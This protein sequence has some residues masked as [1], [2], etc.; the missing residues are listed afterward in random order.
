[1]DLWNNTKKEEKN[2]TFQHTKSQVR[3][4]LIHFTD[5]KVSLRKSFVCNQIGIYVNPNCEIRWNCVHFNCVPFR[6]WVPPTLRIVK[7]QKPLIFHSNGY[8]HFL[9]CDRNLTE[10]VAIRSLRIVARQLV[11]RVEKSKSGDAAKSE[12]HLITDRILEHRAIKRR[13]INITEKYA[14]QPKQ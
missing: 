3:Q 14:Q 12:L 1:M 11:C 5:T 2:L 7:T 13:A 6:Q 10:E 8:N 9:T 4:F